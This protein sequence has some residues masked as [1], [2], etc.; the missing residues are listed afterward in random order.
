MR[1]HSV[2]PFA[3]TA[4]TDCHVIFDCIKLQTRQSNPKMSS[5]IT[6]LETPGFLMP[7]F[8]LVLFLSTVLYHFQVNCQIL[9]LL[10]FYW[11]LNHSSHLCGYTIFQLNTVDLFSNLVRVTV[12]VGVWSSIIF[13]CFPCLLWKTVAKKPWYDQSTLVES[14]Q[15]SYEIILTS[16]MMFVWLTHS[17][18]N[19]LIIYLGWFLVPVES[20]VIVLFSR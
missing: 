6:A 4:K 19:F 11:I 1:S 3:I 2:L 20:K 14:E 13:E 17:C 10:R 8:S 12:T 7:C 5:F 9:H 18:V 15:S 16:I